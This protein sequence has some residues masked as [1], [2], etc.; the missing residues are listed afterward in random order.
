M[1]VPFHRAFEG[2]GSGPTFYETTF[3]NL[4]ACTDVKVVFYAL[5]Y[6][7]L[8]RFQSGMSSYTCHSCISFPHGC[9]Y[10]WSGLRLVQMFCYKYHTSVGCGHIDGAHSASG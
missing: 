3:C 9:T 8:A 10:A 6:V 2:E 7:F 5:F 1:L 4:R